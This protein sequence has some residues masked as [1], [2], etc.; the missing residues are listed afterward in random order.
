MLLH[1]LAGAVCANWLLAVCKVG[2]LTS[3]QGSLVSPQRRLPLDNNAL[4]GGLLAG[5]GA[6]AGA[7]VW[8]VA[9]R[10]GAANPTA[11]WPATAGVAAVVGLVGPL[12]LV[13]ALKNG[14]LKRAQENF[15]QQNYKDALEDAGEAAR[16][17]FDHATKQA[18]SFIRDQ[19][20]EFHRQQLVHTL[21]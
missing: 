17:A 13:T 7:I 19:A 11:F 9:G 10:M 12:P 20:A 1:I 3:G 14:Y 6:V 15:E 16:V 4:V 21:G 8:T 18:A 2:E 5:A